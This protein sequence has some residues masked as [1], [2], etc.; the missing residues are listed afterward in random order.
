LAVVRLGGRIEFG[1]GEER[2]GLLSI[3][4][5]TR[6]SLAFAIQLKRIDIE[7]NQVGWPKAGADCHVCGIASSGHQD[8]AESTI[9]MS[10][11][12]VDPSAVQEYLVPRAEVAGAGAGSANVANVTG[13]VSRRNILAARKGDSEMLEVAAYADALGKNVHR[14]LCGASG[15]VIKHHFVVN[16]VANGDRALPACRE[17]TEEIVSDGPELVDLAIAAGKK[18]LQHLR[19][20][21]MF[22]PES[23]RYPAGAM[24]RAQRL[25]KASR[26]SRDETTDFV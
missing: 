1:R 12:H 15:V 14:R 17:R 8:S 25:P 11:I 20:T 7:M 6:H 10:R 26:Y 16:P 5:D 23:Q 3:G 2:R 9:V 22:Q 18:E 24:K 19:G 21:I 13:D 4:R